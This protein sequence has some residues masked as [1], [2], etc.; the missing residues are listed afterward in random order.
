MAT[1]LLMTPGSLSTFNA[2]SAAPCTK[3]AGNGPGTDYQPVADTRRTDSAL[4]SNLTVMALA[5]SST[6]DAARKIESPAAYDHP[7]RR[8]IQSGTVLGGRFSDRLGWSQPLCSSICL[9]VRLDEP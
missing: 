7:D 4:E 8:R 3:I 5:S 9:Q 2:F 1:R 6:S